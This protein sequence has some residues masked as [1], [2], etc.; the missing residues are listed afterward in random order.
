[1]T[2]AQVWG[3]HLPWFTLVPAEQ[4]TGPNS[5]AIHSS[6]FLSGP[7]RIASLHVTIDQLAI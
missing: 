5:G 3:S 6:Q 2:K 4:W 1:M 7:P